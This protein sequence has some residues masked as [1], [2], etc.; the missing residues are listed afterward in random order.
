MTKFKTSGRAPLDWQTVS[1]PSFQEGGTEGVSNSITEESHSSDSLVKFIRR[2][3]RGRV[4]W[5]VESQ[6]IH[7][8]YAQNCGKFGL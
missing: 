3:W 1:G 2:W 8:G 4:L 6:I 7:F 5:E